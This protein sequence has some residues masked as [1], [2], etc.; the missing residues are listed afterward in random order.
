LPP[1]DKARRA[2]LKERFA[3]MGWEADRMLEALDNA[4]DLYVDSISQ[5]HL[6]RWSDGRIALVGD[7]AWAPS[8]LAGEGCGL[9]IM[10][11]YV[12]AGELARSDG[13]PV[14]FARYESRLRQFIESK[15]KKAARFGGAFC[16]S[17][18]FGIMFRNWVA[19]L[20]NVQPIAN[21]ALASELKDDIELPDYRAVAAMMEPAC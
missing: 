3:G 6:P 16:P 17:T 18:R 1:T 5:I 20:L 21:L 10:G 11:A 2:L 14:A 12:L 13:D 7:A 4:D 8:F 19:S 15:Q 9:G